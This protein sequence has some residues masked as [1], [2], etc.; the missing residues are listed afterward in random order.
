MNSKQFICGIFLFFSVALYGQEWI[1]DASQSYEFSASDQASHDS[2]W[3]RGTPWGTEDKCGLT[4]TGP[5]N[6]F[7]ATNAMYLWDMAPVSTGAN[8][9]IKYLTTTTNS[10]TRQILRISAT[11][12]TYNPTPLTCPSP[13]GDYSYQSGQIYA[14]NLLPAT[15]KVEVCAKLPKE[16]GLW[17]SAWLLGNNTE[18]DIYENGST[19]APLN[20][21]GQASAIPPRIWSNYHTWDNEANSNPCSATNNRNGNVS[22]GTSF[23]SDVDLSLDFHVYSYECTPTYLKVKLDGQLAW[24]ISRDD[25]PYLNASTSCTGSPQDYWPKAMGL[26]LSLYVGNPEVVGPVMYPSPGQ[27]SEMDIDYIRVYTPHC[28]S[29]VI[30][31]KNTSIQMIDDSY[32]VDLSIPEDINYD[33]LPEVN[34]RG[35]YQARDNAYPFL[36]PNPIDWSVFYLT[37][38]KNIGYFTGA[39]VPYMGIKSTNMITM[40]PGFVADAVNSSS[41]LGIPGSGGV[42]YRAEITGICDTG[43]PNGRQMSGNTDNEASSSNV[44]VYPN[45][46]N[47]VYTI[48]SKSEDD[49]I[50]EVYDLFG[51]RMELKSFS[52]IGSEIDIT[53][54]SA[55]LY[56]FK[57]RNLR[58][59]FS[60]IFRIVKQ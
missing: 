10:V 48:S 16:Q 40:H 6:P 1:L 42:V 60:K 32:Q 38:N 8:Q 52:G 33:G 11:S 22:S 17:Y 7:W 43:D 59:S 47:G 26:L 13:T 27:I 15:V 35:W 46:G 12:G 30:C 9:H 45:P 24:M 50:V 44:A 4:H 20:I 37:E 31:D 55:G 56:L 39:S 28:P 18:F 2:R 49:F 51:N 3:E 19:G 14:K 29:Y 54:F 23:H 5:N 58:N 57:I 36:A 25:F 21:T 53:R 41:S 34:E